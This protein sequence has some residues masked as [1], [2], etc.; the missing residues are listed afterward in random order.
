MNTG[1]QDGYNLAWKI[2][3]VLKNG[4]RE[5]LLDTYNEERL[6]NAKRLTETTD[7][8]F[9]L[10]AG[11]DWFVGL[12]RTTVFPP[13]AKYILS[14]EAVRK[15]FFIMISQIG[16]NYREHEM[17]EHTGDDDFVFKAGDRMPY[18]LIEGKSFFD[19]LRA[20][21]FHLVLFTDGQSKPAISE[22]LSRFEF[23]DIHTIPLY[24]HIAQLFGV[25]KSFDVLL[26][27]DNHIALISSENTEE[28]IATYFQNWFN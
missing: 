20:P 18:F 11:N 17:S 6:P 22:E 19:Q 13:M 4:A 27:P 25:N 9:N 5:T 7:R 2:A 23:L 3:M 28:R 26:R 1:I 24:P 8:M 21:K 15:R 10:A 12:I 16:I 14:I